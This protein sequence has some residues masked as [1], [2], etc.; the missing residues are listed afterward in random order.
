M[1]RGHFAR[2]HSRIA[3]PQRHP[4]GLGLVAVAAGL[5]RTKETLLESG[6]ETIN[7]EQLD[8]YASAL[9]A[10]VS[11]FFVEFRLCVASQVHL[12]LVNSQPSPA[13]TVDSSTQ[14]DVEFITA[15]DDDVEAAP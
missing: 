11:I 15:P 2:C 14:P 7:D 3:G 13:I 10:S 9:R 5:A 6:K 12:S 4:A 8:F 1:D